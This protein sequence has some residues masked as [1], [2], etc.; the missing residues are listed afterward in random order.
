MTE[1]THALSVAAGRIARNQETLITVLLRLEEAIAACPD[2]AQVTL[3]AGAVMTAAASPV[4]VAGDLLGAV[5]REVPPAALRLV[6]GCG[7][8]SRPVSLQA[9][10][11]MTA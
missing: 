3:A 6:P 8:P 9:R 5:Y 10:R 11:S 1:M 7:Q 2:S 4:K